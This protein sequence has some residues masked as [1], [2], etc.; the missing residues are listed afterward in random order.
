V[1]GE[2]SYDVYIKS[3]VDRSKSDELGEAVTHFMERDNAVA[4]K[5]RRLEARGEP[6]RV[7]RSTVYGLSE[8][9]KDAWFSDLAA[10]DTAAEESESEPHPD[11]EGPQSGTERTQ[12]QRGFWVRLFGGDSG[13]RGAA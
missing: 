13:G 6:V 10:T 12:E 9:A 1:S 4:L 8:A 7:E 3:G 2:A 11:R 5:R